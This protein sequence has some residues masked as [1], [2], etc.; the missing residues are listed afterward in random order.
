MERA[1]HTESDI[2]K[3]N[4]I[5]EK[6]YKRQTFERAFMSGVFAGLGS[7]VGATLVFALVVYL[8]SQ[9]NLIPIVG[10]WLAV[11]TEQIITNLQR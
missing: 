11:L 2:Q 4:N 6:I 9:V 5:L 1:E 10:D 3:L 8:L 7:A